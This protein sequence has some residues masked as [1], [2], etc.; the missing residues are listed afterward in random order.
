[1]PEATHSPQRSQERATRAL[2]RCIGSD[3]LVHESRYSQGLLL[4]RGQQGDVV[5]VCRRLAE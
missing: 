3:V 1:M 5:F 4:R 2:G